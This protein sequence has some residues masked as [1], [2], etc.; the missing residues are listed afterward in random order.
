MYVTFVDF[1]STY[2][3]FIQWTGKERK[4]EKVASQ[5]PDLEAAPITAPCAELSHVVKR[6]LQI[7]VP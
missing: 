4:R 1:Q 3:S 7:I 6:S 5:V 2:P